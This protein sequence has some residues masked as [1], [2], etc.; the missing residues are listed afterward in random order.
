MF[1]SYNRNGNNLYLT[2]IIVQGEVGTRDKALE[3]DGVTIRPNPSHGLFTL[4]CK[5]CTGAQ[6]LSVLSGEGVEVFTKNIP[7]SKQEMKETIDLSKLS[8]GIYF[9]RLTGNNSTRVG[10]LVIN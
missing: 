7:E 1:E 3:L 2:D 5:Q 9:I 8:K 4:E 6:Y 10:K